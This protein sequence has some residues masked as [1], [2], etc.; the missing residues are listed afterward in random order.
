MILMLLKKAIFLSAVAFAAIGSSAQVYTDANNN[1]GVGTTSPWDK[2]HVNGLI[3]AQKTG[4][5]MD[6]GNIMLYNGTAP[7][8][9]TG[10]YRAELYLSNTN[11]Q[12]TFRNVTGKGY[13][14]VT[15]SASGP[16]LNILD[17]G[18][19]GIGTTNPAYKLDVAGL[20]RITTLVVDQGSASYSGDVRFSQN[21]TLRGRFL[22]GQT[23]TNGDLSYETFNSTGNFVG[24]PFFIQNSSGN[25]GIGTTTPQAKLAVNGDIY[26]KKVKVTQ[27]G[28][29]DYVFSNSY[30]LPSL[31]YVES[32]IKKHKHLPEV[33]SAK[34]VQEEGLNLGDNQALLLQKIEELTLYAI[35][36]NRKIEILTTQFKEQSKKISALQE[37]LEPSKK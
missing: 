26:S 15:A 21:G 35:E 28:W 8:N 23:A 13:Q 14:F 12:L 31:K 27:T 16:I 9:N 32:F 34:E 1:T 2:F 19:V 17:N 24:T 29:P 3:L 30:K 25:V 36:Q 33:P 11:G 18:N 20:T 5:D 4:A 22:T 7:T 6:N 10:E 37:S